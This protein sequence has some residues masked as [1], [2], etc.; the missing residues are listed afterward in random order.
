MHLGRIEL[1]PAAGGDHRVVARG[2]PNASDLLVSEDGAIAIVSSDQGR[3]AAAIDLA[4]GRT[5]PVPMTGEQLL[6]AVS[7]R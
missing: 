6:A 1:W 5:A 4:S 2:L 7:F 3:T